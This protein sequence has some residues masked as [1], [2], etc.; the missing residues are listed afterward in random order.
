MKVGKIISLVSWIL[1]LSCQLV[2][3]QSSTK[4]V[5]GTVTDSN[6][7]ALPGA[8]VIVQGMSIGTEVDAEGKYSLTVP[9][10]ATLVFSMLGYATEEVPVAGKSVIDVRLADDSTMLEEAIV[11]VGYGGQRL[12][13]VT[14]S[15]SR[16][17]VDDIAKA[18]TPSLSDAL[19]GRIAGVQIST[20]DG[21]PGQ[22]ANIVIRGAN[23]LT[24]SNS[25]LYVVDGFPMED[26]SMSSLSSNDIASITVLKDASS[27]AIYGSRAANG[28]IIV[29]TK[30][31]KL[32]KPTFQYS[33]TFGFQQATRKME[34]M[35]PY[36][37]VS[38]QIERSPNA[39]D[40]YLT[41]KGLTLE[42]YKDM[43]GIN[44]QDKVFVNAPMMIH[45]VSVMGGKK[46]YRY[47]LSGNF[48]DQKGVIINSGY[49]KFQVR[50]A[51]AHKI[52]N[53]LDYDVNM[54]YMEDQTYGQT[55][56]AQLSE[57][58]SYT[59]HLMYRVWGYK[60]ILSDKVDEEDLFDDDI[61]VG[62]AN[63]VMNPYVSN[64]NEQVFRK[65]SRILLNGKVEFK[66]ADGL[67]LTVKGGYDRLVVRREEFYNSK[68]Y[69]GYSSA[70]N[71][72]DVNGLFNEQN[73]S[74]WLNENTLSYKKKFGKDHT[75]DL[76][77]GF[78]MQGT[79]SD[80]FAFTDI[81]VPNEDLGI[82][83]MDDGLPETTTVTLSRN[84]LMSAIARANY[85]L[86]GRYLFTFSLR[87][88]GSSKFTKGHRWGVFPSGAFAW[89]MGQ[90]PWMKDVG[91]I[92]DAKLRISYG[93][94]G[95]N[96]IGDFVAYGS[97]VMGDHYAIDNNI[98][99][100]MVP[101]NLGNDE[102]TWESTSQ[103]DIGYDIHF[104]GSRLNAT[105]DLYRKITDN[106]LLNANVPYSSGYSNVYKNVG[107]VRNDGLELTLNTVNVR[108]V[109]FQWTSDFNIAFNR[110]KVL[111][112][113]E[114][115]QTYM[116]TVVFTGDFNNTYLYMA[117]VGKPMASF[118]GLVWDGV[119]GYDD[120]D[121]TPAGGYTLRDDVPTN[122]NARESIKPG[123][124]KYV[125]Q[126]KDGVVDDADMVV[127]GRA[128][129]ICTGGFNN[130]FIY[131]GWSL[132]V[133]FQWS[134]GNQ[135][136]N[137]NRIVFEG[138]F[139]NKNINQF[140]SYVDRWSDDNV[141]SRNFRTGGYGP[142]GKYSTRTLE[143]GS[144][145]RLK[146]V[147]L[148]YTFPKLLTGKA[149]I[150]MVQLFLSGQNLWTLTRYSGL[151]PEVSTRHS[152]LTPGF[153]YSS[154]ARNRVYT[155]GVNITF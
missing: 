114:G 140:K 98:K 60:P 39:A 149:R 151:D 26:F 22:E 119:Y 36:D 54:S 125:D 13:D 12:V 14:G 93:V 8:V 84:T 104:F 144:F 146:T 6:G 52:N 27:T 45:N 96:R 129:P 19:E 69:K 103:I 117:K 34:M 64:M 112:L 91:F 118:Y 24:Q 141:D 134:V 87:A 89:R 113:A 108:T 115:Q 136:M 90:E 142:T 77:A 65:K 105:I 35:T 155:A 59:T 72:K 5:S 50:G 46:E 31:G 122:G 7:Q 18:P 110:D 57:N 131:K 67:K 80:L 116:S 107:K 37:F 121:A 11:E 128:N 101:S 28:V 70:Y 111:E 75:L 33:G 132:N 150:R 102:L 15:V 48:V 40:A 9:K 21:Q 20:S 137:A 2:S 68:T 139:A 147:Q 153:D 127:I 152:A 120:F 82:S 4:K 1:L 3:A 145:L 81:K 126:N 38:Y 29:E 42:D 138:N 97:L 49:K 148:S 32:D 124:I 44:W 51:F 55:S 41:S 43:S 88:D 62:V 83:G 92:D 109:N 53:W 66:L 25:P 130:N 47:N 71:N 74:S 30:K 100:A 86:F 23:S 61:T 58:N 154:Y 99:E 63:A 10:N 17:N 56:S 143:D 95:N 94:T 16:V 73:K 106:L 133:F 76:L 85:Q 135:I 79:K 123:D 78:T